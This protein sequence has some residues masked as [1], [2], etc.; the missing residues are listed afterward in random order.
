MNRFGVGLIVPSSNTTMEPDFHRHAGWSAV[1]S[2]ARIFLEDVTRE[3]ELKMIREDLPL[4]LRIMN[5]AAPEAIVFGC[6]SAGSLGGV[7]HDSDIRDL[8]ER[9][10]GA[11]GI[12]V[13]A[14]ILQELK[15]IESRA[16]SVFTPYLEDL[17]RSVAGCITSGGFRVLQAEGMQLTKNLDI[18]KVTPA[19]IVS[20]V[21]SRMHGNHPDCILLSCTNWRAMEAIEP[22]RA[23]FGLPV[24]T[25][26]QACIAAVRRIMETSGLQLPGSGFNDL[27]APQP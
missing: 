16:V 17:T 7:E 12:T 18:G 15:R 1:I 3:A 22:L 8:I 24:I 23:E 19:E 21:R 27:G 9:E 10:T 6:T 25:S 14:S 5:S 11:K 4:A 2:T 26:N 20:F 13:V